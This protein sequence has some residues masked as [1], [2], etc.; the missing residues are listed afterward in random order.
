MVLLVAWPVQA[1]AQEPFA[2]CTVAAAGIATELSCGLE[3]LTVTEGGETELSARL[4]SHLSELGSRGAIESQ[5]T[6]LQSQDGLLPA[7]RTQVTPSGSAAPESSWLAT[8]VPSPM[9]SL[10]VACRSPGTSTEGVERCDALVQA[11]VRAG[12]PQ[13][14]R[15]LTGSNGGDWAGVEAKVGRP[16]PR[17]LGCET[18]ARSSSLVH[19][20][21]DGVLAIAL[22]PAPRSGGATWQRQFLDGVLG[23]LPSDQDVGAEDTLPCQLASQ[24]TTCTRVAVTHGDGGRSW[25]ISA[26]AQGAESYF[27]GVCAYPDL[28]FAL[29]LYCRSLF[30]DVPPSP[31]VAESSGRGRRR[32]KD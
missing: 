23:G 25:V 29:P 12:L 24:E 13:A 2:A 1:H 7:A 27:T 22:I 16:I 14:L 6:A 32:N 11:V 18:Q 8:A 26:G 17:S 21:D 15:G 31:P 4:A 20:C 9:G 3:T 28:G 10:L 5:Q 30:G 19:L